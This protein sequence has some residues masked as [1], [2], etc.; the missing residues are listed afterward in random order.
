VYF[1]I[2]YLSDSESQ[3]CLFQEN[4]RE[5]ER[6]IERMRERGREGG[7]RKIKI[8]KERETREV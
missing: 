8:R 6:N 5:R 4:E 1:D 3:H 2:K 7:E